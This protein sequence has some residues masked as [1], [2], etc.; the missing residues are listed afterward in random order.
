[1]QKLWLTAT[2]SLFAFVFL[3]GSAFAT[4]VAIQVDSPT[5]PGPYCHGTQIDMT[6]TITGCAGAVAHVQRSFPN[7]TGSATTGT[8]FEATITDPQEISFTTDLTVDFLH[9]WIIVTNSSGVLFDNS[10][11]PNSFFRAEPPEFTSCATPGYVVCG[12]PDPALYFPLLGATNYI[13]A[14]TSI[15][16]V[17]SA[18]CQTTNRIDYAISNDCSASTCSVFVVSIQDTEEPTFP[19]APVGGQFGCGEPMAALDTQAVVDVMTDACTP[20][21]I[22]LTIRQNSSFDGCTRTVTQAFEAVDFCGNVGTFTR[23]ISYLDDSS[24]PMIDCGGNVHLGCN[25]TSLSIQVSISEACMLRTNWLET[26]GATNGCDVTL[27]QTVYAVDGCDNTGACSRVVTYTRDSQP[28]VFTLNQL[29]GLV[30][31]PI[32]YAVDQLVSDDCGVSNTWVEEVGG[33]ECASLMTQNFYAVDFC[34]NTGTAQRVILY[35]LDTNAP[36]LTCTDTNLGCDPGAFPDFASLLDGAIDNCGN[37]NLVIVTSNS[38]PVVMDGCEA[39][40]MQGITVEDA[41]G[42]QASCSRVVRYTINDQTAPVVTDLAPSNLVCAADVP[43]P[44]ADVTAF[45]AAGGAVVEDCGLSF[46]L[47]GNHT[48]PSQA[49]YVYRFEDDCGNASLSTQIF[50]L[51]DTVP[52]LIICA[53]E[54]VDVC[55]PA[56]GSTNLDVIG[57]VTSLSD[58]C[59]GV[60]ISPTQI[61]FSCASLGPTTLVII[62]TDDSGNTNFCRVNLF[63]RDKLPPVVTCDPG[64]LVLVV[65]NGGSVPITPITFGASPSDNCTIASVF[66]EPTSVDESDIGG[67]HTGTTYAVDT[68]GN[69]GNC[70]TAYRVIPESRTADLSLSKVGPDPLVTAGTTTAISFIVSNAGPATATNV[71]LNASASG[72]SLVVSNF[73]L[74]N[75]T[76][77]AMTSVVLQLVV[78]P[79]ADCELLIESLVTSDTV[80]PSFFLINNRAFCIPEVQHL[81]DISVGKSGPAQFQSG[82][83]IV[84]ELVVSNAGPSTASG[85]ALVDV[86]PT[87]FELFATSCTNSMTNLDS[88][89]IWNLPDLN[90]GSAFICDLEIAAT[91]S[92][93]CIRQSITNR[94]FISVA[95]QQ[96]ECFTIDTTLSNNLTSVNTDLLPDAEPPMAIGAST[97]VV[98]ECGMPPPRLVEPDF[99]DNCGMATVL[100]TSVTGFN[101][102][103]STLTSTTNIWTGMDLCQNFRSVTQIVTI[104][105]TTPPVVISCPSN[106]TLG[107]SEVGDTD[108]GGV[109]A[110]DSCSSVTV[111]VLSVSNFNRGVFDFCPSSSEVVYEIADA[112]GNTATCT[113][114]FLA[115]VDPPTILD[116]PSNQSVTCIA[117][118]PAPN[119]DGV[120]A[121]GCGQLSISVDPVVQLGTDCD[122][123]IQY[124]YRVTDRCGGST[125]CTQAITLVDDI[126]PVILRC[127]EDDTATCFVDLAVPGTNQLLATDNCSAVTLEMLTQP[128]T[129]P[130]C[131]LVDTAFEIVYRASDVCGNSTTCTQILTLAATPLPEFTVVPSNAVLG[132]TDTLPG[133]TASAIDGCGHSLIVL[134]QT[135]SNPVCGADSGAAL[136]FN[137]FMATDDCGRSIRATQVI[138]IVDNQAPVLNGCP[139]RVTVTGGNSC[140]GNIPFIPGITAQDDCG[141]STISQPDAGNAISGFGSHSARIIATDA[142]GHSVTCVVDVVLDCPIISGIDLQKTVYLGHDG[143][144]GC[145][146]AG[147]VVTG[148]LTEAIT[149]CFRL[150]NTGNYPLTNAVI[151]DPFL[152]PPYSET[153]DVLLP[154]EPVMLHHEAAIVRSFVNTAAVVAAVSNRSTTVR[155]SDVAAVQLDVIRI[156]GIVWEDVRNDGT[157]TND[158]LDVVGL[159]DVLIDLFEEGSA[160]PSYTVTSGLQGAYSFDN[161]PSGNYRIIPRASTVPDELRTLPPSLPTNVM[162]QAMAGSPK[163]EVHFGF[164]PEP[165]AVRLAGLDTMILDGQALIYWQTHSENGTLGFQVRNIETGLPLNE[166]LI[167]ARGRPGALYHVAEVPPGVYQLEE[168][169]FGAERIIQGEVKV[170]PIQDGTPVGDTSQIIEAV[171]NQAELHTTADFNS[172][173]VI[174]FSA[175]PRATDVT[176][177]AHPSWVAGQVVETD[178]GF[179]I[180]FS[181]PAGRQLKI[182]PANA[183]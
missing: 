68:S 120:V 15:V 116:C 151:M 110:T 135:T 66:T 128:P 158:N 64:V 142:C 105:D 167:R 157:P 7:L 171:D 100:F 81:A 42:N 63:I 28:P 97:T 84:Y 168:V 144:G 58:N 89:V 138:E 54:E 10:D 16:E 23:V 136:I 1:M 175:R 132:C 173:L 59:G 162:I 18:G 36:V 139:E 82:E 182:G 92:A 119:P 133:D 121:D 129:D 55:L 22:Q 161:I 39:S 109:I 155:D 96:Q 164:V 25:P 37:G 150:E 154:G 32:T 143:G 19:G 123:T 21:S 163:F 137:T 77:G 159:V 78:P 35:A 111:T 60:G 27:T 125:T 86:I 169:T 156:C 93:C 26:V 13:R 124:I 38:T 178:K 9:F 102:D 80:D 98:V 101:C 43:P 170:L 174:G 45:G 179:G 115:A 148:N 47:E 48:G 176:D 107:C 74:G 56:S 153:V 165:T 3:I 2:A 122:G 46:S 79:D 117:D 183:P 49:G 76:A 113:Q 71:M 72:A 94:A 127:P 34:G 104:V 14:S 29:Q 70:D 112:C 17:G 53:T 24:P 87:G 75:L 83:P 91:S 5:G 6:Y 152:N 118:A 180:Y 172:T 160:T 145:T 31:G 11:S 95:V 33:T 146:G 41:C 40:Y 141:S 67:I 166:A 69:T 30:C 106:I 131:V 114:L 88:Q 134:V 4:N 20:G 12:D 149:Y 140:R 147:E 130:G 51:A 50:T 177:P 61:N 8:V 126:A 65:P 85:I 90:P 99:I 108:P 62:A 103:V 52:P 73:A 44:L 57:L 181:L